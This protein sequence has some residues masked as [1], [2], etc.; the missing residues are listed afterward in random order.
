MISLFDVFTYFPPDVT[1]SA[2]MTYLQ[3]G[4]LM[5]RMQVF[6]SD[7]LILMRGSCHVDL[8]LHVRK[9]LLFL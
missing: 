3:Q 7:V 1:P 2:F 5:G 8:L 4:A 6:Y 9:V